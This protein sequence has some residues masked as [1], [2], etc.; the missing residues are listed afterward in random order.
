MPGIASSERKRAEE[1]GRGQVGA[2][3]K[4]DLPVE[5]DGETR[6]YRYVFTVKEMKVLGF[7]GT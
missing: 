7:R 2:V 3:F 4:L 5:L 1:F 6:V